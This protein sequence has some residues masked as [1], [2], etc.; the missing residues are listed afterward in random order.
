[1]QS[2]DEDKILRIWTPIILRTVLIAAGIVLIVG[3]VLMAATPGEYVDH[4][5]K[6]QE[7]ERIKDYGYLRWT[8]SSAR[9]TAIR[10]R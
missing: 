6:V 4:F 9:R 1:M 8:C 7:N 3:L 5:R 2:A 10:A